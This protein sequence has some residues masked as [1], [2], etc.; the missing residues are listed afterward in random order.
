MSE[1]SF[2]KLEVEAVRGLKWWDLSSPSPAALPG[3][4][5]HRARPGCVPRALP[6]ASPLGL[7]AGLQQ[8]G[9]VPLRRRLVSRVLPSSGLRNISGSASLQRQRERRRPRWRSPRL[10]HAEAAARGGREPLRLEA[11]GPPLGS[12]CSRVGSGEGAGPPRR[13][14]RAGGGV[15]VLLAGLLQGGSPLCWQNSPTGPSTEVQ[16]VSPIPGSA[17]G[18]WEMETELQRTSTP[19]PL[20]G[21]SSFSWPLL[22]ENQKKRAQPGFSSRLMWIPL[23]ANRGSV[24]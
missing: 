5:G 23:L 2:R 11:P 21:P 19:S 8:A 6:W 10:L 9:A 20:P 14:L 3:S 18:C 24:L 15:P 12:E 4:Q 13:S 16:P 22:R 17:T 1:P 7:V